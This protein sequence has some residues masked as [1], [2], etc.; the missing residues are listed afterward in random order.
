M[1]VNYLFF[2]NSILFAVGLAVDAFLVAIS[3][4]LTRPK[5]KTAKTLGVAATFA[6]FHMAA[7]MLG[8]IIARAAFKRFEWIELCFAWVAVVVI[9]VL[10][11]KMIVESVRT[12]GDSVKPTKQGVLALVAQ[13][14]A[15]SVDALTVGF[16]I[17]EY[18]VGAALLC[19]AII[20]FVTFVVYTIGFAVGKKFGMRF[21]KA[22]SVIG[23]IVFIAI[24]LEIIVTTYI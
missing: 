21:G 5:T 23:G 20:S 18:S 16:T 19:S 24:A 6:A 2:V 1:R 11:I 15:T 14:A 3:N 8:F 12:S 10:G 13:C 4:G 7:P 17:E 9:S 22:A